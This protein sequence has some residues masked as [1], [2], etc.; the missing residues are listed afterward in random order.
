MISVGVVSPMITNTNVNIFKSGLGGERMGTGVQT[1]SH[2]MFPM[3]LWYITANQ[4]M[5]ID[6]KWVVMQ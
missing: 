3:L 1:K 6:M 5:T 4:D 2:L